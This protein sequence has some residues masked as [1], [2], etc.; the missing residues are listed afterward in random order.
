MLMAA[1]TGCLIILRESPEN[2]PTTGKYCPDFAP[3]EN[4][5]PFFRQRQLSCRVLLW[6]NGFFARRRKAVPVAFNSW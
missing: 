2:L 1:L 5:H 3:A 6:P 4:K